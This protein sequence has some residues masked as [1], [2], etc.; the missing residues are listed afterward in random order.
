VAAVQ[1]AQNAKASPVELGK[2]AFTGCIAFHGAGGEGG[3]GPILAGQSATDIA[4]K[5]VQYQQGETRGNQ[6]TLMWSQA[7]QFSDK[8]IE[9]LATYIETL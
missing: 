9:H 6:S 8:N 7:A 5:L 3:V 2:Q 4:G 1:G